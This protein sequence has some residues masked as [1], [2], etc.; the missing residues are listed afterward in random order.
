MDKKANSAEDARKNETESGEPT[1][2]DTGPKGL[3][4]IVRGDDFDDD[5]P[6][7]LEGDEIEDAD[8]EYRGGSD[9]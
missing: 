6:S 4:N 8:T 5:E 3:E 9:E 7:H 2:Q 1:L